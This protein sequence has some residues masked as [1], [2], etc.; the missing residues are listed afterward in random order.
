M[1]QI[2]RNHKWF[3]I[4]IA[5]F[6]YLQSIQVR[7]LVRQKVNIYTFT[8]D[9]AIATFI[10]VC[11]LFFILYKFTNKSSFTQNIYQLLLKALLAV[12]IYLIITNLIS[13]SISFAFNNIHRNFNTT[14]VLRS[15]TS[16]LLNGIVYTGFYLVYDFYLKNKKH[17]A[18]IIK[19]DKALAESKISQLKAQLNPHFLFNNLNILDQLIY[20]DKDR[21]SDF[22]TE[23]SE[24]YRCILKTS[25][26]KLVTLEE[27]LSFAYAY[28]NLIRFRFDNSYELKVIIEGDTR[29]KMLPPL[30]LQLLIEN[31]IEHNSGS[32]E[33]PNVITVEVGEHLTVSNQLRPKMSKKK[34]GGRA[35]K[36]LKS[37]YELLTDKKIKIENESDFFSISL[38]LLRLRLDD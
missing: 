20:E 9:G 28:F 1:I 2:I 14:S 26:K 21:A 4:L 23:F 30:T 7:I 38:P 8:P 22:L 10:S 13:F 12:L 11:I 34:D 19:Y 29:V 3:L 31:V 18:D 27:E 24:I 32:K 25:D 17:Q 36:N 16:N 37:Q 33:N 35:L 6:T 5:I 15:N